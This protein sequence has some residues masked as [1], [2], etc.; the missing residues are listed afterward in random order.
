M[1]IIEDLKKKIQG[2][3]KII[4]F[5][6]SEDE[7]ILKATEIL[8]KKNIAKPIL[9]GNSQNIIKKINE[10]NLNLNNIDIININ[11]PPEDF[12]EQLF[13]I[14]RNK[15]LTLEQAKEL[16]KN[17]VYYGTMMLKQGKA[18]GLIYG[19]SHPTTETI[20]PALQIIK[21]KQGIASS[22][23]LM[24]KEDKQLMYAD[25]AFVV[26]PSSEEL[27]KIAI[28]TAESAKSL[29]IEPKI[30]MLS[31]ST[32]GSAKHENVEKV[33]KA[34]N[35]VKKEKPD[36]MIEGEIQLDTALVPEISKKKFP[37]SQIKGNANIL[38]FP[39]LNSG[40]IAYKI[41]QRLAG[42]KAIGPIIQ[43]LNKPVNDL[44]RGCSIEDII[45][46]TI[47]TCAQSEN[48]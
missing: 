48:K 45:N 22:Y 10:L 39:D 41:T 8:I 42:F 1:E 31:F 19:A 6:E 5:P 15:G 35:I 26:Q 21:T 32:K 38:I 40:N 46:V 36:L 23:F 18:D 11:N 29:N 9:I 2:K 24:I 25:C 13:E 43:G 7:R 30:A 12:S 14:R 47:I 17:P 20:K 4:I 34:T 27:A 37:E 3:E 28:Q 44:S 16:L 33:S